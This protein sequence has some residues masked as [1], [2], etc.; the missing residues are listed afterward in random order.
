[1]KDKDL[2]TDFE[3]EEVLEKL[4]GKGFIN[5]Q[6]FAESWVQSRSRKYGPKRIKQE[7]AQKGIV[8]YEFKIPNEAQIAEKLLDR[9]IK[10]WK[11]LEGLELKKK[12]LEFLIRRGFEFEV[13]KEVV[14]KYLKKV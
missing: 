2:I 1:M 5:D 14:E 6:K 10:A 7:L 8:N 12:A 3:I 13:A 11:N 4:K 9:K